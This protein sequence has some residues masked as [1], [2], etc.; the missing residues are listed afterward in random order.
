[1][2]PPSAPGYC[3]CDS[4]GHPGTGVPLRS[5]NPVERS[6]PA[7]RWF[8]PEPPQAALHTAAP[9]TVP[10]GR[11]GIDATEIARFHRGNAPPG[12]VESPT[13]RRQARGHRLRPGTGASAGPAA[14]G[15][16]RYPDF[17]LGSRAISADEDGRPIQACGTLS[18]RWLLP[19]PSAGDPSSH[20]ERVRTHCADVPL[21]T[22]NSLLS[23]KEPQAVSLSRPTADPQA[24]AL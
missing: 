14:G 16:V 13:P 23:W 3:K 19:R 22:A 9:T 5:V 8:P 24:G 15:A 6:L 2:P 18:R 20:N 12:D 4:W 7:D 1:M 21:P 11:R 17:R 10:P